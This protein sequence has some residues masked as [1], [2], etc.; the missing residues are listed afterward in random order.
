MCKSR[1]P[2]KAVTFCLNC[3]I[4]PKLTPESDVHGSGAGYKEARHL[5]ATLTSEEAANAGIVLASMKIRKA[6]RMKNHSVFEPFV[7][8]E[9]INLVDYR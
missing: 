4:L 2:A 5:R 7:T 8:I 3:F 9:Q 6:D 1:Q